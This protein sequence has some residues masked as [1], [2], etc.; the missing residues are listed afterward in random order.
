MLSK[1]FNIST[2]DEKLV[3]FES[4]IIVKFLLLKITCCLNFNPL[5]FETAFFI[6]LKLQ[7]NFFDMAI[8]NDKFSMFALFEK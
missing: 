6:E 8:T 7:P 2:E 4:L 3:D 5:N 1:F